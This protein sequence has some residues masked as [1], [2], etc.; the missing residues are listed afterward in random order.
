MLSP[1]RAHVALGIKERHKPLF[2]QACITLGAGIND[3]QLSDSAWS[4]AYQHRPCM[5]E[6]RPHPVPE[7]QI[8]HSSF[9]YCKLSS[10]V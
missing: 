3:T 5:T 6:N 8:K 7:G 9:A 2:F 1:R 10:G 4:I